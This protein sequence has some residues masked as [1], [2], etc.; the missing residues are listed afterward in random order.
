MRRL[1]LGVVAAGL[2]AACSPARPCA[3]TLW[4]VDDGSARSVEVTGD[5]NGWDPSGADPLEPVHP[6]AWTVELPLPVGDHRY[7]LRV[8]GR[9]VLD[10][11]QPLRAVDP[12]TG[13]ETSL[14]RMED[15]AEPK[16]EVLQAVAHRDGRAAARVQFWRGHRSP[17]VEAAAVRARWL[18]GGPAPSVAVD[19]R[20]GE[21]QVETRGLPAGKH[22]LELRAADADGTAAPPLRVPLW[23]EDTPFDWSDAVIYQVM[24]DR[25][26]GPGG[27]LAP[28]A[29][30]ARHGGTLDG[31]RDWVEAGGL[32][33]LSARA[34]WLS[35]VH[36]NPEGAF[37]IPGGHE[38]E[39][40]H[41]YWWTAPTGV[42][43]RLGSP[44]GLDALI[45]SAH[46]QGVRVLLDVVP[47]HIHADHPW[48]EAGGFTAGSPACV[49]GSEACP[50]S[51]SIE[52]C[53]FAP[54][55]PDVDWSSPAARDAM[56]D[57]L[58]D[59][60]LQHDV[61]GFRVDAVPMMPRAAIRELRWALGESIAGPTPFFLIGETFTGPADVAT[62]R[63]NLGPHGLSSQFDFP[64][65]WALRG[66]FAG[67]GDDAAALEA[68]L[69]RSE[70]AWAGSGA[71]MSPFLGNHDVARFISV[72]AGDDTAAPWSVQPA[73]PT[74]DAPYAQMAAAFTALFALPGAPAIW[75][76]DELGQA[77]A[78]DPDN[79]RP[80]PAD[81]AL[82]PAQRALRD[83]VAR[84]G[85]L[86]ACSTALRRGS[87]LP[88]HADGP[89]FAFARVHSGSAPVVLVAA[90]AGGVTDGVVPLPAA[91]R[92]TARWVDLLRPA[93]SLPGGATLAVSLP[94]WGA[95]LLAPADSPCVEQP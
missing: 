92:D 86:R 23:V 82:L 45:E 36:P 60:A 77:G 74:S 66:F 38:M 34:L 26:R 64:L 58:V 49:C 9:P 94:P 30:G 47:N 4:Y 35:P 17:G 83:H 91:L 93:V 73:Q 50:W 65:M 15:C 1:A 22:T 76:G 27:A 24:I 72:A 95:R 89:L 32:K 51:T 84:L 20:T 68:A 56:R 19:E 62:I 87:R 2:S 13:A 53:W 33:A 69:S 7:L 85:A 88:L 12:S 57:S 41:G 5:W 52:S 8:D 81:D 21:I 40:Y 55:L 31:L 70:G 75:Q 11:L 37:P 10:L 42:D 54:Y 28:A 78:G 39:G 71:V 6:G 79:R 80:F 61:D 29:L 63:E 16:L 14:L 90:G 18:G 48:A 25:F 44:E 46:A 59:L 3:A 43:P 67:A